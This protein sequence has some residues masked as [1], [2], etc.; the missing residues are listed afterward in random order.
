MHIDENNVDV[1]P[2]YD[3]IWH[4]I[5]DPRYLAVLTDL[6]ADQA[7]VRDIELFTE[8]GPE[9][10]KIAHNMKFLFEKRSGDAAM[11]ES[12]AQVAFNK[13]T[14]YMEQYERQREGTRRE[15]EAARLKEEAAALAAKEK[16]AKA[17]LAVVAEE[18]ELRNDG[19]RPLLT[20]EHTGS[21]AVIGNIGQDS[22][23]RFVPY[24]A[25][26]EITVA[27]SHVPAGDA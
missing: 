23:A 24:T 1:L 8:W 16:A 22:E 25:G 4:K 9:E 3:D 14:E 27:E 20:T 6:N 21:M 17:R 7:P 15:L 26:G 5:L 2:T 18:A 11:S 12:F 13:R 19:S 10:G